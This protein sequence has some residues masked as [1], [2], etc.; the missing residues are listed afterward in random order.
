MGAEH[1]LD[2]KRGGPD[3]DAITIA[4]EHSRGKSA[5]VNK[6][7]QQNPRAT[8]GAQASH[9]PGEHRPFA[10]GNILRQN[11]LH[12]RPKQKKTP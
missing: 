9:V 11:V 12:V 2:G 8:S 3:Y 5:R 10:P 4:G 7:P 6:Q 1:I